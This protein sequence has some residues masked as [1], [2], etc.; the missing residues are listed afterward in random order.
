MSVENFDI[1][2]FNGLEPGGK[3]GRKYHVF[4][5]RNCLTVPKNFVGE[6]F[7]ASETSWP[8]TIFGQEGGREG[9]SRFS[10]VKLLSHNTENFS[11]VIC[12]CVQK[13]SAV[14]KI[15]V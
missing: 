1:D 11:M 14:G 7:G 3:E 10:V 6:L 2:N 8:Q 4:P 12:L 9:V 13:N 5:S 15:Y